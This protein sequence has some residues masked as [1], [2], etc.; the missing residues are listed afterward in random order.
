MQLQ[1]H[2][3]WYC[4]S[5]QMQTN[6]LIM[7]KLLWLLLF[8][9]GIWGYFSDPFI[10]FWR[11]LDVF[12]LYPGL[13]EGFLKV[14]FLSCGLGLLFNCRVREM[15]LIL[16]LGL[17]LFLLSSKPVFRNHLFICACAFL[18]CGLSKK[19]QEPWLLY[20]QLS[21]IYFGAALNKIW[22]QD[23][24]N[25]RFMHNWLLNARESTVY[26]NIH[27]LL[28]AH[29][30]DYLF[31]WGALG[32]EISIALMLLSRKRRFS[33]MWIIL[34]FHTTL[35]TITG[36][37]FGHFFEDIVIYLL[38]FLVIPEEP[39]EI[40]FRAGRRSLVAILL[41]FM[42]WNRQFRLNS[43]QSDGVHWI[44]LSYAG[45]ST[46]DARAIGKI[47]M[48]SPATYFALLLGDTFVRALFSITGEH[49]VTATWLW[50][51][52]LFYTWLRFGPKN[53]SSKPE[54]VQLP[55]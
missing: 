7:C 9:N 22:Q 25:G 32:V 34:V 20:A 18:L 30:A 21:L 40:S 29:V 15:S 51:V 4:Q 27:N 46:Y 11:W 47:I 39:L 12:R 26:E 48:F 1:N 8:I 17:F 24:W 43:M 44:K 3:P 19:H 31:S 49:I 55:E 5:P 36:F 13:F 14:L 37:R 41:G 35:Y 42:D 45:Q 6:L 28:P 10:P 2:Y 54:L 52:I 53:E 50:A 23:W 38:V 33:A 16:G